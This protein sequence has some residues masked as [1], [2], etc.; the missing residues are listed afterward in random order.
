MADRMSQEIFRLTV[1]LTNTTPWRGEPRE[2]SL[3]RAF[4]SAHTV[5][6]TDGPGFVSLMDP[7]DQLRPIAQECRNIG[8]WPVLVGEEGE[9]H[10]MLASP[11][12]LYDHPQIA[13][14]SPGDLFDATEIDQMLRL[15]VRSLTDEERQEIRGGDPLAREILDQ[16]DG[17]T[18]EQLMRLHGVL[19]PVSPS[20]GRTEK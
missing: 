13:P 6:R 9:R 7:P 20:Q 15:S 18:S 19:R 11:I 5:L 2:E 8:L 1:R 10:T 4:V 12:I 14:E 17:L 16:S 3:K